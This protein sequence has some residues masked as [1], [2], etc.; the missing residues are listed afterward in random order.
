M[1]DAG[2][3]ATTSNPPQPAEEEIIRLDL[4]GDA[5][6]AGAVARLG[7]LRML[8]RGVRLMVFS[9]DGKRAYSNTSKGFAIWDGNEAQRLRDLPLPDAYWPLALAPDESKLAT[10]S[11]GGKVVI[12][13]LG[14][15]RAEV[16]FPAHEKE[17]TGLCYL[18]KDTLISAAEDGAV[19]LWK[20]GEKL[21][22]KVLG[23][24]AQP[25]TALAC[26][27]KGKL[28]IWGTR[29]GAMYWL[30]P[31]AASW[32]KGLGS[33]PKEI[34]SA[35][36]S[37]DG[38][39]VAFGAADANIYTWPW[40]NGGVV[41]QPV[42][43]AA[44]DRVVSSVALAE[45]GRTLYSAGGDADFREWNTQTGDL[46]R[47]IT[48]IQGLDAQ[49]IALSPDGTRML[50]WSSYETGRGTEGGRFWLWDT[51]TGKPRE[52]P[53]RHNDAINAVDVSAASDRIV[54]ASFDGTVRIWSAM[55]GKELGHST[56]HE[57]RV[58]AVKFGPADEVWSAGEDARIHIWN[59]ETRAQ[60]SPLEPVGGEVTTFD[61]H[62]QGTF[63]ATGDRTGRVWLYELA[64]G[65]KVRSEDRKMFSA[66][67]AVRF[68]PGGQELA[69]AGSNNTILVTA[70]GTGRDVAK[71][72][73]PV[74]SISS[75]A[76]SP[77]Q[78]A[79]LASATSDHIVDVWTTDPWAQKQALKGHDGTVRAVD[80]SADGRYLVSGGNDKTVRIWDVESGEN[81]AILEGHDGG[82]A[83]VA[84]APN[85]A[86]VVSV[87]DDRTG[88]VWRL[89]A[90]SSL[91]HIGKGI[92]DQYEERRALESK[93]A[94]A[95]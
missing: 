25:V 58:R 93:V 28:V 60:R 18:K 70:L 80:W 3:A 5:L 76:F 43:I 57:G 95:K 62:P 7:S 55:S 37:G 66:I 83:D 74:T 13:D 21:E 51:A 17:I 44:H 68:A 39:Q 91:G 49:Y 10:A 59:P 48:G 72:A 71:L 84:F 40:R 56:D 78:G 73:P 24:N 82:V 14:S 22:S 15:Y 47:Q 45:D 86:F 46:V 67:N 11:L 2:V 52:E 20:L 92:L 81:V 30:D 54:T 26:D 64:S 35:S 31:A 88:L 27:K 23:Q 34:T 90:Q 1:T 65:K 63:L 19:K 87:S 38:T 29:E 69:I 77:Q 89:R 8:E 85:Q 4:F 33:A 94:P 36:I 32:N 41:A 42:V 75:I 6:P 79:F 53:E 61:I 12:W 50:S 16:T 9:P